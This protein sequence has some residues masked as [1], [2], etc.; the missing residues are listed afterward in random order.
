MFVVLDKC[1]DQTTLEVYFRE[2]CVGVEAVQL[3]TDADGRSRG[4][5]YVTFAD[6]DDAAAAVAELDGSDIPEGSGKRLK[7]MPA[8]EPNRCRAARGA[9]KAAATSRGG[10]GCGRGDGSFPGSGDR[11]FPGSGDGRFPG[12]GDG[13]F[14]G[15]TPS[16]L[17][18]D[19]DGERIE[20]DEGGDGGVRR[21]RADGDEDDALSSQPPP[22][23]YSRLAADAPRAKKT[24][25]NAANAS[26]T[27]AGPEVAETEA[28]PEVASSSANL[29]AN[30]EANRV[31][32]R[33]SHADDEADEAGEAALA[34]GKVTLDANARDDA[35][36]ATFVTNDAA[37]SFATTPPPAPTRLF[38]ALALPL[39][40]YAVRHVMASR[41]DVA[42]LVMRRDGA[43]G[44]VDFVRAE[45]ADTAMRA[46]RD[47]D[48][49]GIRLRLARR[50]DSV[51]GGG[52][53]ANED[54]GM[55]KGKDTDRRR[56]GMDEDALVGSEGEE[57]TPPTTTP[58][59]TETGEVVVGAIAGSD[60]DQPK[61]RA[62][63][64][65]RR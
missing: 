56:A 17:E 65:S 13:S 60:R 61:K 42:S 10:G 15:S 21:R 37:S 33:A 28:G 1:V 59:P 52:V 32:H 35:P 34:L 43:S 53:E 44:W 55:E 2:R 16:R 49:L 40:S 6:A 51:A 18:R 48:V 7:V 54:A 25:A 38:F 3:K 41:G 24:K 26:E 36:R 39:P 11:S 23:K 62:R 64:G 9:G 4:F 30:L 12:S 14:P 22:V 50:A 19:G 5:A 57:M 63:T 20:E 8:E 47:V 29:E 45:H 58:T 27:E 31:S 46:L